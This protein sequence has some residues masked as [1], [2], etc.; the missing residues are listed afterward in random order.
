MLFLVDFNDYEMWYRVEKEIGSFF[1][2]PAVIDDTIDS[3]KG[4]GCMR[5]DATVSTY[6]LSAVP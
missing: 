6:S 1:S 4:I 2:K 3:E 5:V